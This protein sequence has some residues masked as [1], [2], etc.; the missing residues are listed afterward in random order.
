MKVK[1]NLNLMTLLLTQENISVK[2]TM[3][4]PRFV[5]E[6]LPCMHFTESQPMP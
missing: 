1:K 2:Y 5:F 4:N 6:C 3:L